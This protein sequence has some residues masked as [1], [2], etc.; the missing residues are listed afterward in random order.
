MDCSLKLD[1][2]LLLEASAKARAAHLAELRSELDITT[3]SRSRTSS[4]SSTSTGEYIEESKH[5]YPDSLP[6]C[7]NKRKS[8]DRQRCIATLLLPQGMS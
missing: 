5:E 2:S 7:T 3:G 4:S 1:D 8:V 6:P